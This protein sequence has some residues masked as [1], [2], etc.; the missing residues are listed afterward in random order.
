MTTEQQQNDEI[1]YITM[2][3]SSYYPDFDQVVYEAYD[4]MHQTKID[5]RASYGNVFFNFQVKEILF[6]PGMMDQT[7]FTAQIGWRKSYLKKQSHIT[8]NL[9]RASKSIKISA[10]NDWLSALMI[11]LE[12]I[13]HQYDGKTKSNIDLL[14][15]LN[16]GGLAESNVEDIYLLNYGFRS[17]SCLYYTRQESIVL[18]ANQDSP[19]I[20]RQNLKQWLPVRI[21]CL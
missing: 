8:G 9:P 15:F 4:D 1:N 12:K 18:F 6:H 16:E 17:I 11:T 14:I 5:V 20:L 10:E 7:E 2:F 3:L 21:L 13:N 19:N